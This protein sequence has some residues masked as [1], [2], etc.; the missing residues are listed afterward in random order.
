MISSELRNKI[1]LIGRDVTSDMA[2]KTRELFSPLHPVAPFVGIEIKRDIFYGDDERNRLD[3]FTPN[4]KRTD[5]VPVLVFIHGG[6]FVAGDKYTPGSPFYDNI[7]TWA[8]LH[9][10]VG[11]NI[12]YRLAPKHKWPAGIEDLAAVTSWIQENAELNGI[13]VERIYFMGQSAGAAHVASYIAHPEFYQPAGHGLAGAILLSGLYDFA[14]LAPDG[15]LGAYIGRDT[16]VY[17]ERSSVKGLVQDN[18]PMMFS[19]AEHEPDF[20]EKQALVALTA[21]RDRDNKMPRFVHLKGHNHL[22]TVMNFGLADDL[23]G[24]EIEEFINT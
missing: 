1:K 10:M 20:F 13:D 4:D 6:G 21:I 23:L 15:Y 7:G 8:V 5:K 11:I 16:S 14:L 3:I 9:G 19:L 22:S 12:T 24:L 18:V 2:V 17:A